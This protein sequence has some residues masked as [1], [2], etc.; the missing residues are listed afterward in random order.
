VKK[1]IYIILPD[2]SLLVGFFQNGLNS[3]AIQWEQWT[4]AQPVNTIA[5]THNDQ[6]I[7]GSDIY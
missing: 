3:K 2:R 7:L 6:D 4:F 5:V 1:R